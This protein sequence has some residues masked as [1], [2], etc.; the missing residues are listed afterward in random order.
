MRTKEYWI[1]V[2]NE[3]NS[4]S[5][6]DKPYGYFASGSEQSDPSV[7]L[8]FESINALIDGLMWGEPAVYDFYDDEILLRAYHDAVAPTVEKLKEFGLSEEHFLRLKS[9]A[10]NHINLQW[11]GKF[12]EITLGESDFSREVIYDFRDADE[13]SISRSIGSDELDEFLEFLSTYGV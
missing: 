2:M 7:F 1:G 9:S 3:A 13:L 5:P 11:M 8:W 6:T 12:E 10:S 4:S